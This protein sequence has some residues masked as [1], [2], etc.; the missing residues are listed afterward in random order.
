MSPNMG[1]G[2]VGGQGH[3]NLVDLESL[4]LYTNFQPRRCLGSGVE[5]FVSVFTIY[6]HGGH[7]G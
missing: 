1:G 2:G 7:L 6:G 4:M 5:A 3:I